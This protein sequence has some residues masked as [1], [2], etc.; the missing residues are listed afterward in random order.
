MSRNNMKDELQFARIWTHIARCGSSLDTANIRRSTW[1]ITARRRVDFVPPKKVSY[2]PS[3]PPSPS[4]P[5]S[6]KVALLHVFA[7]TQHW[8]GVRKMPKRNLATLRARK[9][10]RILGGDAFCVHQC[11]QYSAALE[12]TGAALTGSNGGERAPEQVEAKWRW[13][14]RFRHPS[15]RGAWRGDEERRRCPTGEA[16]CFAKRCLPSR[17]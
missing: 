1:V 17:F 15:T 9:M 2:Q 6:Q 14:R 7:S 10:L 11:G 13:R 8:G 4:L 12:D 5:A 3:L 16:L